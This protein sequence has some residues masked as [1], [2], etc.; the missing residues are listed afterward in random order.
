MK[1]KFLGVSV[2]G[3]FPPQKKRDLGWFSCWLPFKTHKPGCE[4]QKS[5][6]ATLLASRRKVGPSSCPRRGSGV[7]K[8]PPRWDFCFER[9]PRVSSSGWS[10]GPKESDPLASI[11]AWVQESEGWNLGLKESG[12]TALDSFAGLGEVEVGV[13]DKKLGV[14]WRGRQFQREENGPTHSREPPCRLAHSRAL[15]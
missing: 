4:L 12:S 1:L 5:H 15:A 7:S 14:A 3:G 10:F 9:P 6:R 8:C 2:L 13:R 11:S